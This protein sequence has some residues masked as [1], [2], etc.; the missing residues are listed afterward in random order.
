MMNEAD[1][2][3]RRTNAI[4][5]HVSSL[6]QR[7]FPLMHGSPAAADRV[8]PSVADKQHCASTRSCWSNGNACTVS[9]APFLACG[10]FP[11]GEV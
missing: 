6:I 9:F 4:F 8:L 2:A 3:S 7:H 11:G 10:W 5:R 1:G